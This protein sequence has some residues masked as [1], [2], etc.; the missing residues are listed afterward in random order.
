MKKNDKSAKIL[1]Y[2][3]K[4]TEENNGISPTVREIMKYVGAAST[5]TINYQLDKLEKSGEIVR[6]NTGK[7]RRI[8]IPGCIY[9]NPPLPE[10][11]D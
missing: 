11:V 1:K 4:Y 6:I 7:S 10:W 5:N 2:I 8:S 3:Y 9:R